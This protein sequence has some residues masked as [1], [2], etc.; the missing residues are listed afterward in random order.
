ME[1]TTIWRYGD[2]KMLT[3]DIKIEYDAQSQTLTLIITGEIDHHS[4]GRLRE[5]ADRELAVRRP[6]ELVI[7]VSG[8]TFMDSSGLGFILGRYGKAEPLGATTTVKGA[9]PLIHR[10]LRLSGAD[11][12]VKVLK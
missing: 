3:A 10:I 6:K 1:K 11:T 9:S 4:V 12:F 5:Q 2:I 8:V 7:D